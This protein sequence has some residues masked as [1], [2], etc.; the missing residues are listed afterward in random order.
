MIRDVYKCPESNVVQTNA[1][2][3][4]HYSSHP[5]LMPNS[6]IANYPPGHPYRVTPGPNFRTPYRLGQVQEGS[7]KVVTMDGVQFPS[8]NARADAFAIDWQR[9]ANP[10]APGDAPSGFVY[11]ESFLIT[12]QDPDNT[13]LQ[14]SIDGGPNIDLPTGANPDRA[15][16][17]IRWRHM[18]NTAAV[19]SFLDG[20]AEAINYK[21]R[22][23]T[24][25]KR[26][27]VYVNFSPRGKQDTPYNPFAN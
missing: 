23:E 26:Q 22:W 5:L 7:D 8:G 11:P 3:I 14:S 4:N 2:E 25:L 20:H 17:N 9:I 12:D 19:F 18:D 16:G 1:I 24:G 21:S 10:G 27:N 15:D 6:T 13:N